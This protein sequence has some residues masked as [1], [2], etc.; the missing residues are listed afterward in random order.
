MYINFVVVIV[1]CRF[2]LWFVGWVELGA[3]KNTDDSFASF[4]SINRMEN[5]FSNWFENV[6]S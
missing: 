6:K 5:V 1:V 2:Y 3:K 4:F